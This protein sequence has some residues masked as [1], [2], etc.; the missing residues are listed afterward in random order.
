VKLEGRRV[1]K[2]GKEKGMCNDYCWVYMILNGPHQA[3]CECVNFVCV[4]SVE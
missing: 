1:G 3:N 4:F 2:E